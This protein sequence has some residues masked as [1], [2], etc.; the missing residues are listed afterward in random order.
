MA[1]HLGVDPDRLLFGGG[2]NEL[3]LVTAL[4]VGGPGTSAVFAD[5][6][7]GLYRIATRVAGA[8]PRPVVLDGAHRHDL[9]AMRAAVTD[10][11]TVVYVC[12]PNNPTG[13]HVA[14][15]DLYRFIDSVPERVLVVVDEA[16]IEFARA[17][18]CASALPLAAER[19]NV[20]VA[21]T[22]S[23]V[24]GLAGLRVG[25]MVGH[26]AIFTE[27][28][29]VQLPFTVSTP[30][31]VAAM[32]AIRHQDRLDDRVSLN[33]AAMK[34]FT[35]ELAVRDIPFADSQTNFVYLRPP[36]ASLDAALL[37]RGVIVRPQPEGWI[38]VTVGTDQENRRFF[39]A[40]DDA[41]EG[42]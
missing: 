5:P 3:M 35:E 4:A 41:L 10:D 12:N 40:L 27:L 39:A 6:S 19:D 18:D 36:A 37:R 21:R 17:V 2:S 7:F 14:A 8:E 42:A 29:K 38:R 16:Y 26:P 25:Y 24:Y 20:V 9:E 34:I 23:K 11:T 1:G 33:A 15:P 32:E 28:R 31:Q 13:T 30:A 22:F